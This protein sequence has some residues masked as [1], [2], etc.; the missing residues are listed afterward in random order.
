[1]CTGT[2]EGAPPKVAKC[3]NLAVGTRTATQV[4]VTGMS[5]AAARALIA[6]SPAA[7]F[8]PPRRTF[9]S[10]FTQDGFR[11]G[12][13]GDGRDASTPLSYE[14]VRGIRS[15]LFDLSVS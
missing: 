4:L 3:A 5:C 1:V 7:R 8:V 13:A 15:F 11:C 14:C 6:R 9:V 12:T 2:Y 10:R